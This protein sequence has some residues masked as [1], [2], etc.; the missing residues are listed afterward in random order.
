MKGGKPA[1]VFISRGG[2]NLIRNDPR[3]SFP[4]LYKRAHIH[5]SILDR[6]SLLLASL[7]LRE[8]GFIP[9]TTGLNAAQL[10]KYLLENG[11][12]IRRPA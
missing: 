3:R 8:R 5:V 4:R 6:D 7:V 12:K 10:K 11:D 1:S 2:L 9:A